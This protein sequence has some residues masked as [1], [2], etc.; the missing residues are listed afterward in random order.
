MDTIRMTASYDD[1]KFEISRILM[2]DNSLVDEL[3]KTD[4]QKVIELISDLSFCITDIGISLNENTPDKMAKKDVTQYQLR[5]GSKPYFFNME[6]KLFILLKTIGFSILQIKHNSNNRIEIILKAFHDL[7]NLFYNARIE[8]KEDIYCIYMLCGEIADNEKDGIIEINKVKEKF[9]GS[10]I[11]HGWP[12]FFKNDS[13][14]SCPYFERETE[15][16]KQYHNN[17]YIDSCFR[18]LVDTEIL[19]PL[20][21][22]KYRF[23]K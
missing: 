19:K 15:K 1:I 21:D 18:I 16:C 10:P 22:E 2:E 17:D 5:R 6:K 7:Y 11:C 14:I 23:Y 4:E 20:G 3:K 8:V 12:I 9:N 13:E